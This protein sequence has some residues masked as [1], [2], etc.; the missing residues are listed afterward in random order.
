[1]SILQPRRKTRT[2]RVGDLALGSEHPIRVQSM[3]KGDTADVHATFDE[4]VGLE[5]TGCELVRVSVPSMKQ[6]RGAR[7]DQAA[8]QD[9]ARRRHPLLA[10]PL[11]LEA[12]AQGVDKV[13]INPGNI[14]RRD[15]VEKVVR[16][17]QGQG[18]GDAHRRELRAASASARACP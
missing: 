1:M 4:I 2:V 14:G 17:A 7:R 8:D 13:R 16:A 3:T 10:R 11:A 6:A 9:P 15:E 12:I 18:R 5:A